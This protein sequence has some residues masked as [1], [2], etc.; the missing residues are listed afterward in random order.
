[1]G[2]VGVDTNLSQDYI[3]KYDKG[4]Q[5]TIWKIAVLSAHAFAHIGSKITDQTKAVEGMLEVVK[6][7][8][9]GFENFKDKDGKDVQFTTETKE[10]YS[11]TYNLVSNNIINIIPI[12]IIIELGGRILEI[13][14]LTEQEIKN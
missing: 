9:R 8:L 4:E 2:I 10:L 13:T 6:F 11:R 7:G 5:K 12:D 14:K 3:S 1:M